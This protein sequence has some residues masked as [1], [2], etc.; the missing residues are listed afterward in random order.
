MMTRYYDARAGRFNRPD[1]AVDF[2]ETNP[3]SFNLY[4]YARGNPV[5]YI[6]PNGRVPVP[7]VTGAIGAAAGFVGSVVGQSISKGFDNIDW[8]D[9]AIA[10]GA[11][12]V[13]G[14]AAPF[15]A[16]KLTGAVLLGAS[17]NVVQYLATQFSNDD[18]ITLEGIGLSAG[19]GAL[20]GLTGGAFSQPRGLVFGT[21]SINAGN[22]MFRA[23]ARELN[24]EATIKANVGIANL[25]RSTLAGITS[26]TDPRDLPKL[27][28]NLT[29]GLSP[30]ERARLFEH[31]R[32]VIAD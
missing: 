23:T 19:T 24:R 28:P 31:G 20:A 30:A 26:N 17:V 4:G 12:A 32:G 11:G 18:V 8:G 6:D 9:A 13:A 16:T 7:V 5:N 27:V 1:P 29:S 14:A 2:D 25:L 22:T 15:V 21:S 10:A 3:I